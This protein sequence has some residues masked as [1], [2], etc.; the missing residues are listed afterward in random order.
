MSAFAAAMRMELGSM[1]ADEDR[2]RWG[3]PRLAIG[4]P[5]VVVPALVVGWRLRPHRAEDIDRFAELLDPRADAGVRVVVGAVL[6][7]GPARSD[8]Q[9]DAPVGQVLE[10]GRHLGQ[11]GRISVA[12]AQ[13]QNSDD[14]ARELGGNERDRRPALSVGEP[15]FMRRSDTQAEENAPSP[16][17]RRPR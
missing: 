12:L 14:V 6:I 11:Q 16:L 17:L 2:D 13:D 10:R 15:S 9:D 1:P 5:D 4:V 3:R 7:L 8:A